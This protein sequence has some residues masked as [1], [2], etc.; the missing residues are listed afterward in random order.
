[1]IYCPKEVQLLCLS[2][3]I[4]NPEELAGWISQVGFNAWLFVDFGCLLD[5]WVIPTLVA[6]R[7]LSFLLNLVGFSASQFPVFD[8]ADSVYSN[9][10]LVWL[11][12]SSFFTS[13]EI[14]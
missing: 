14:D 13:L 7:V 2:A 5:E 10:L 8:C 11:D 4:A 3:T 12:K 9:K 1:M 6:F